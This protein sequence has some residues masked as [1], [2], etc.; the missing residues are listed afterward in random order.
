VSP[1]TAASGFSYPSLVDE[2][3]RSGLTTR[4]IGE[5][6]G[7][8]ERQVQNWAAGTSRPSSDTRDRLVD[9]HYIVRQ[10]AHVYRPEGIEIWLHARNAELEGERPIELLI[11]GDFQPVVFA[12]DRL[13]VGAT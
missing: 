12:V 10:L 6:T 2:I 9:V 1:E 3:R 4:E 8:R 13:R 11:A 7:V 5:I